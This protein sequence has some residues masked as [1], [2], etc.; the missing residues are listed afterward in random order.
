M[1]VLRTV[2][3]SLTSLTCV[4]AR[5]RMAYLYHYLIFY[6]ILNHSASPAS[7]SVNHVNHP[8]LKCVSI[9]LHVKQIRRDV[10]RLYSQFPQ[11]VIQGQQAFFFVFDHL[12]LA[13]LR[14]QCIFSG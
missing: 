2:D 10:V 8:P 14:V 3:R 4:R 9:G 1:F 13:L 12:A 5:G 6:L 11:D 7:D